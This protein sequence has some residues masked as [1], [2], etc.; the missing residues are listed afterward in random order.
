MTLPRLE[1]VVARW[2]QTPPLSVSVAAI[3]EAVGVEFKK[4]PAPQQQQRSVRP[5]KKQSP[6]ALFDLLGGAA[7]IGSEKPEWLRKATT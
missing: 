7:G 3:A 6:Q 4:G 2:Q 1:A 5:A